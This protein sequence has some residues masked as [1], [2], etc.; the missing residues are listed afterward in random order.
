MLRIVL[1]N[2]QVLAFGILSVLI[3]GIYSSSVL[4]QT[5]PNSTN[6][7]PIVDEALN[8]SS[9]EGKQN[10]DPSYPEVCIASPPPD[11]NCSDIPQTDFTV[12][13]PDP[14]GFDIDGDGIGCETGD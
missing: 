3:V 7:V 6:N 8:A 5:I 10:C 2:F 4:G 11:L 12:R 14:H 1:K 9:N 13:Q